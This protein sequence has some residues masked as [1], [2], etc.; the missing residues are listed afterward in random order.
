MQ[1]CD[2]FIFWGIQ[3]VECHH[4]P[5]MTLCDEVGLIPARFHRN[6]VFSTGCLHFT[7][8]TFV[9]QMG[10]R[11][12]T[13]GWWHLR[14]VNYK[15][16]HTLLEEIVNFYSGTST[17]RLEVGNLSLDIKRRV[18]KIKGAWPHWTV[19]SDCASPYFPPVRSLLHL[20]TIMMG[21][22]SLS[23][24]YNVATKSW[25][26]LHSWLIEDTLWDDPG[27]LHNRISERSWILLS[28]MNGLISNTI[29]YQISHQLTTF[30]SW[31][32]PHYWTPPLEFVYRA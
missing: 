14:N 10:F 31:I 25:W 22:L 1:G 18:N 13:F 3:W 5:C 11:Y 16:R 2:V 17:M 19:P 30:S 6:R 20:G 32:N 12:P 26:V 29:L 21:D 4:S 24:M 28:D 7:I 8:P 27:G 9:W 15:L 23:L